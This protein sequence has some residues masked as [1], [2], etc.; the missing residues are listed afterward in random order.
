MHNF[1]TWNRPQI[2]LFVVIVVPVCSVSA[3][4]MCSVVS[5]LYPQSQ[6]GRIDF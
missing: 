3:D 1:K 4:G 6:L 2:V 5:D